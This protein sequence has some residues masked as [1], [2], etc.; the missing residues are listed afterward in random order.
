MTIPSIGPMIS[1]ALVA[2]I[3]KGEAFDRA[4]NF[5]AWVGLASHQFSTG[6]RTVLGGITK[7]GSRYLRCADQPPPSDGYR[8]SGRGCD[9]R[10]RLHLHRQGGKR[11]PCATSV[12]SNPRLEEE[13][14]L[15]SGGIGLTAA[16]ERATALYNAR[17]IA[18]ARSAP[19]RYRVGRRRYRR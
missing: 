9:R 19:V 13:R 10:C 8:R 11:G 16:V 14:G 15:P 3:G 12:R 4:S 18:T 6:G 2:A 17:E 5:A 7:Q 1:T